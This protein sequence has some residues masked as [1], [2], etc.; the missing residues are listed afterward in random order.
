MGTAIERNN[1]TSPAHHKPNCDWNVDSGHQIQGRR[2]DDRRHARH[3][4]LNVAS[5]GSLAQ[6]RNMK[7]IDVFSD[8]LVGAGGDMSDW[9][10]IQ[11]K[12]E[13][14]V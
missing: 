9:Q 1:S 2:H 10:E 11:H 3:T 14:L 6:I 13:T 8:V 4:L 12:L 7:R 5:Y